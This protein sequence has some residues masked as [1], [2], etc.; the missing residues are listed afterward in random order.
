M[1][2]TTQIMDTYD[3]IQEILDMDYF[4]ISL[5]QKD[6]GDIEWSV[7]YKNLNSKDYFSDRNICLLSSKNNTIDDVYRLA[8]KFEMEKE[9][10]RN[11]I[12]VDSSIK[13]FH[14]IDSFIKLK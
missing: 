10:A 8:A 4:H 7:F 12:I 5:T 6:D 13:G 11:E 2:N 9:K 14:I 1:E 3:K